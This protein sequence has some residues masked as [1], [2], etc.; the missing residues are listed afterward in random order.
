MALIGRCDGIVGTSGMT[1][2]LAMAMGRDVVVLQAPR[3]NSQK[4]E[5]SHKLSSSI[6][7]VSYV[8]P[9]EL[10]KSPCN[11]DDI[12]PDQVRDAVFERLNRT[13]AQKNCL[14]SIKTENPTLHIETEILA[15][16]SQVSHTRHRP[17]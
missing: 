17:G 9:V 5:D 3:Q 8:R 12:L 1:T 14:K 6:G 15:V 4:T 16:R 11:L 13:A 10:L 2:E 7:E